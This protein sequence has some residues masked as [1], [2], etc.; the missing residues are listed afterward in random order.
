[1]VST[2]KL[3]SDYISVGSSFGGDQTWF[4]NIDRKWKGRA[5]KGFGCGLIGAADVL[6]YTLGQDVVLEGVSETDSMDGS[7]NDAKSL[8]GLAKKRS[9]TDAKKM[10]DIARNSSPN[11]INKELYMAYISRLEKL[12]FHILP[13][14]GLSGI[15]MALGVNLFF[16]THR[17]LIR[18]ITGCRFRAHWAVRPWKLLD[19]IREMLENDIPVVISIGPGFLRKD[20]VKLYSATE[21][22]GKI[23][24]KPVTQ[25][26]DHYV[27]VTGVVE[28][29]DITMIE[30]SS[31]GK[32]YYINWKEYT[33]YVKKNDNYF[34]SNILYIS[35][36]PVGGEK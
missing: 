17:R 32:R 4:E 25:T 14:L 19:K 23:H 31:W 6:M 13:K 2:T 15:L 16:L 33:D 28:L 10:S 27:T 9:G 1:M 20:K 29:S 18:N 30:I 7:G 21:K 3:N 34:F 12:Y 36:K 22:N 8:S 24:Y 5:I 35:K 26:K 11:S